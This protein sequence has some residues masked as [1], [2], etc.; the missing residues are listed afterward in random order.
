MLA[1]LAI[2]ALVQGPASIPPTPYDLVVELEITDDSEPIEGYGPAVVFEYEVGFDGVLHA[3][4]ISGLDLFIRVEELNRGAAVEDDDDGGGGAPYVELEVQEGDYLAVILASKMPR[5][6]GRLALHLIASPETEETLGAARDA[7]EA[8]AELNRLRHQAGDF[9]GA[10]KLAGEICSRLVACGGCSYSGAV[11]AG[12]SSLGRVAFDLGDLA[13]SRAVWEARLR[14]R[15]RVLPPGHDSL[16][17][18]KQ[19]LAAVLKGLSDLEGA[20][21]LEESVLEARRSLFS[22]RHPSVLIAEMNLATTRYMI[23]ELEAAHVVFER[24]V[25]GLGLVAA[26]DDPMLLMAKQNL[27]ATRGELGDLRGAVELEESVYEV[28]RRSMPED[29]PALLAIQGNLAGSRFRLGDLEAAHALQH[30]VH[31]GFERTLPGDHPDLLIAK[32]GLAEMRAELGDLEGALALLEEVH[33]MERASLPAHHLS[34]LRTT[35]AVAVT[36]KQL[37][38]LEGARVLEQSVQAAFLELLPKGHPDVSD[39][40]Q[41]LA[42]TLFMLGEYEDAVAVSYTM[43][44]NQSTRAERLSTESPRVARAGALRELARLAVPLQGSERAD[45]NSRGPL[46]A[47]LFSSLET[48]R[49]VSTASSSVA[50]AS[51]RSPRLRGI[52]DRL[53]HTRRQLNDLSLYPPEGDLDVWRKTMLE[54]SGERDRLGRELRSLL[55]PQSKDLLPTVERAARSLAPGDL[56]VSFFR[57]KRVADGHRGVGRGREYVDWLIAFVVPPGGGVQR[58][59][60]GPAGVLETLAREW[61]DQLGA[62][63]QRGIEPVLESGDE[64]ACGERLRRRLVDPWLQSLDPSPSRL[65][66]VLD[67]FLHLLPLEALPLDTGGRLGDALRIRRENTVRRLISQPAVMGGDGV[68]VALGGASFAAEGA[69]EAGDLS[70][71]TGPPMDQ[72]AGRTG[73]SRK[74]PALFQTQIEAETLGMLYERTFDA[75]PVVLTGL[76]ATKASL[77]LHA[78]K[79]R[80]LHIA[81][82][83]WFA[84]E[85]FKSMIDDAEAMGE[86]PMSRSAGD[87]IH[88]FAPETLCGLALAGADHGMN[89]QGNV[90]GI[91]TA[92]ELATLDLS[93]CELAVLSA[94]ET[95]V[96]IRRAGQGIQSLQTALHTAGSRTA[97]TSLWK[98][99][100]A[101]TRK[102]FEF[103]YT[104]LW[105]EKMGKADALWKAK[106][107]LRDAGHPLRDWAGWVLTGDPE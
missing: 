88:G 67:D 26:D 83:G 69:D 1:L 72:V 44:S 60:L 54:L 9:E 56:L 79:A 28:R 80:Y 20:R 74:F 48:L 40:S 25:A 50:I 71:F 92:E 107:A 82:H 66:L 49:M 34:L 42:G 16:L 52:R 15:A 35:Q 55:A 46:D 104:Y 100:D 76:A 7:Q 13:S 37:G 95:N 47:A 30:A 73:V 90:P 94:C 101:A 62:P 18:A 89:E 39:A 106:T 17:V 8:L 22:D 78:A 96:G 98:V 63:M 6:N 14:H 102:L 23:G 36:R 68:L 75:S 10:R 97:I 24:V 5:P 33:A 105:G 77:H 41:N 21:D 12:L 65:L 99:D 3:W 45:G 31:A 87:T 19:D 93:G 2:L 4:A 86:R 57:Y 29:H 11:S 81:T 91:M 103:F 38:D 58:F 70:A 64:R 51:A 59:D 61:R 85:V 84:S 27:A 43:L 53:T 32:A